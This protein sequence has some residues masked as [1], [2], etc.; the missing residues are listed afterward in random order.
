MRSLNF[1]LI[2]GLL[3]GGCG[4]DKGEPGT[5]T[6][7]GNTV[8][9]TDDP[10]TS[11][12]PGTTASDTTTAPDTITG[13]DT[14]TLPEDTDVPETGIVEG[15]S[16]MIEDRCAPDDG[17]ALEFKVGVATLECGADFPED[18]PQITVSLWTGPPLVPGYY[19]LEGGNG[20]ATLDD[21]NGV[22]MTEI[23]MISVLGWDNGQPYGAIELTF[24]DEPAFNDAFFGIYC[25]SEP[26]CK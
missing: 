11:A 9:S 2:S 12:G 21:G 14:T 1:I 5:E 26:P 19:K 10:T 23:G 17:P 13:P 3:T 15:I 22:K 25:P 4:G 24:P 20:F 8:G 16:V 7:P 18:A 6:G